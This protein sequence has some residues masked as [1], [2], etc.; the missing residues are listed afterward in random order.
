[1]K[2][3]TVFIL[4]S[5]YIILTALFS[6]IAQFLCATKLLKNKREVISRIQVINFLGMRVLLRNSLTWSWGLQLVW[7]YLLYALFI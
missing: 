5:K 2:E 1:M 3:V 7:Q 4:E 6:F